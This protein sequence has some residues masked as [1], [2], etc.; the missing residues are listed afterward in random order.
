MYIY[1]PTFNY[2]SAKTTTTAS[3]SELT[4][5]TTATSS[6]PISS[7]SSATSQHHASETSEFNLVQLRFSGLMDNIQ[8]AITWAITFMRHDDTENAL[9]RL[10]SIKE[11]ITQSRSTIEGSLRRIRNTVK[12]LE[13]QNT[14]IQNQLV[15]LQL[16]TS[17]TDDA[18][19]HSICE[20]HDAPNSQ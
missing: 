16:Q 4:S 19:M 14:T 12:D 5:T 13:D 17:T 8:H 1:V 6:Q 18:E 2:S 20:Q 15:D 7:V 9:I 11:L 10:Q 3:N